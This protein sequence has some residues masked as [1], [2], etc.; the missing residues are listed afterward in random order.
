[1]SRDLNILFKPQAVKKAADVPAPVEPKKEK[2]GESGTPE[3]PVVTAEVVSEAVAEVEVPVSGSTN[4]EAESKDVGK[5]ENGQSIAE[6]GSPV[7][8]PEEG[9]MEVDKAE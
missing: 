1:M 3:T 8:T 6:A 4:M 7:K 2:E 9:K 5:L